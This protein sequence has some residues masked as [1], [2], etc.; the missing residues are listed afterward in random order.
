MV[1]LPLLTS[2]HL[3]L[4]QQ[5]QLLRAY[6]GYKRRPQDIL[7]ERSSFGT[8]N[9]HYDAAWAKTVWVDLS[10]SIL[11]EPLIAIL[12]QESFQPAPVTPI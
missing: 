5:V 6:N 10:W 7:Q 12:A 8:T 1:R 9:M 3:P 4:E 2:S 11:T